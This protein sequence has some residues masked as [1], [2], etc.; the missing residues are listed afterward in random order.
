MYHAKAGGKARFAAFNEGMRE[1]AVARLEIETGL[2]KAIDN[3]ELVLHYQP[4]VSVTSQRVIGYEALVRWNH[5]RLGI[6]HP[7]EF[8]P[9][10]EESDLIVLVGRWVLN[11]LASRWRSGRRDSLSIRHSRSASH[12]VET[13]ERRRNC[14]GRGAGPFRNRAGSKMPE[15]GSD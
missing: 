8:I 4:E 11:K 1:R 14:G 6:R 2:R 9:V 12:F 10:A 7:S 15:T 3:Q 13:F 5:P